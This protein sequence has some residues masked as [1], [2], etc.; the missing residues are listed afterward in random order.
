CMNSSA[1]FAILSSTVSSSMSF[2]LS[3]NPPTSHRT[4]SR[5][6]PRKVTGSVGHRIG[7]VLRRLKKCSA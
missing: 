6:A 3:E 1:I 2:L 7:N 5:L 4:L